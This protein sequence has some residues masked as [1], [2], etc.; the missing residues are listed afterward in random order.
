MS[1]LS[2][3]G[4]TGPP[5]GAVHTLFIRKPPFLGRVPR[6]L[7]IQQAAVPWPPSPPTSARAA[8]GGAAA[9][10][11]A[12]SWGAALPAARGEGR[13]QPGTQRAPVPGSPGGLASRPEPTVSEDDLRLLKMLLTGVWVFSSASGANHR[14][15]APC[16][17]AEA[18]Q[19]RPAALQEPLNS[20][21][22][23][24]GAPARGTPGRPGVTRDQEPSVQFPVEPLQA[25][26]V[27]PVPVGA[28]PAQAGSPRCCASTFTS[29]GLSRP[30]RPAT[31]VPHPLLVQEHAE[32]GD[33][34]LAG[35]QKHLFTKRCFRAQFRNA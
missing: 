13:R 20:A 2:R 6:P 25:P 11:S 10:A 26:P 14:S 4:T 32:L 29:K 3:A 23:G 30:H 19:G 24:V 15:L 35:S 34:T 31:R 7:A 33:S 5:D 9:A 12:G 28:P 22:L 27:P 18:R 17:Q 8:W 21:D 1:G 16:P